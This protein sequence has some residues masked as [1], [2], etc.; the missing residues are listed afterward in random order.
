MSRRVV[1]GLIASIVLS[2][3]MARAE[4]APAPAAGGVAFEPG[5]PAWSDVL[6]KA[7]AQ[8]KPAF[9]DFSTEWCGWCRRMEQDTF[10]QASV[11]EVMKGFVN[12]TLDAEQGEG[13]DLVKRYGVRGF[14]TML[15]VDAAGEEV[16][17]IVGYLPPDEFAEEARRI[18]RGEGTIPALR[19]KVAESPDDLESGVRLA[20]KLSAARPGDAPSLF[21]ALVAK[22]ATA[23]RPTQAKV[24]LAYASALLEAGRGP[25]ALAQAETI[26]KD[27]AD[28]PAAAEVVPSVGRAVLGAP[29]A[30]AFAFLDAARALAKAPQARFQVEELAVML[31]RNG[32][33][34]ALARQAE[35]AGDDPELLNQVAWMSFELKVNVREAL[36]WAR[37][38]VELS[39][40]APEILDTLA[41]LQWLL[42]MP[43]EAIATEEKAAAKAEGGMKA[44]FEATLAGWRGTR[45]RSRADGDTPSAPVEAPGPTK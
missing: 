20:S 14:P 19:R 18:L 28:T 9:V 21:E 2:A 8:A 17:R 33:A 6:A 32:M 39:Q 23:D 12:V 29:P 3:G 36:D 26:L 34:Q 45:S 27:L 16:D 11:G 4:E 41:N 24:R 30:R 43:E 38:A 1:S 35:A 42:D 5:T 13:P 31:H 10:S 15:V 25:E 37:K 40:G 44:Q 7:K 22:S